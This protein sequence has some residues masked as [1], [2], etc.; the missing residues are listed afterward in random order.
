MALLA[1]ALYGAAAQLPDKRVDD[2]PLAEPK[3]GE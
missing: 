3:H 2:Q 1:N